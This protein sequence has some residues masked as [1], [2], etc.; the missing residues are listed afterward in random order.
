MCLEVSVL[1]LFYVY[2]QTSTGTQ[3]SECWPSLLALLRDG[4]SLLPPALFLVLA[5]LN[6]FVQRC[7]PPFQEKKDQ[8][9]LQDITSKVC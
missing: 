3:L 8:R 2:M 4:L 1:E 6:E 5:I 9:D 7:A